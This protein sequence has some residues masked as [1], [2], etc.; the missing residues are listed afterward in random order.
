MLIVVLTGLGI[1]MLSIPPNSYAFCSSSLLSIPPKLAFA[2][3][4]ELSIEAEAL[5]LR[6]GT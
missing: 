4:H 3:Q 5:H 6:T 1:R 2:D